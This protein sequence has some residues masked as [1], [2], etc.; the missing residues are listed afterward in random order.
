M[1]LNSCY[2]Y[3]ESIIKITKLDGLVLKRKRCYEIIFWRGK[4]MREDKILKEK[5]KKLSD[6][7]SGIT[8]KVTKNTRFTYW[9]TNKVAI[10]KA[11]SIG[12]LLIVLLEYYY[13]LG[14]TKM[15]LQCFNIQ[16]RGYV[17]FIDSYHRIQPIP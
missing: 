15:T 14:T 9:R 1:I 7:K 12:T 5:T 6:K 11:I 17:I 8:E 2:P 4:T 13:Y 10:I 3:F 16:E